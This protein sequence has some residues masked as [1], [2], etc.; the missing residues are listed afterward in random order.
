MSDRVGPDVPAQDDLLPVYA[1]DGAELPPEQNLAEWRQ[2]TALFFDTERLEAF[3]SQRF[4]ASIRSYRMGPLLYGRASSEG[5]RFIRNAEVVARGGD[6]HFL[7]QLYVRGSYRGRTSAGPI[8]VRTG[9]ISVLDLADTF[10]TEAEDFDNLN[11]VVPRPLLASRLPTTSGLHG[12]VLRREHAMTELLG[13][14][15]SALDA[16]APRLT[17]GEADDL[18]DASLSFIAAAL[19]RALYGRTRSGN[20]ELEAALRIRAFVDA[21]LGDPNLDVSA[22][23]AHFGLSRAGLYRLFA[24][25]GRIGEHI[26]NERLRGAFQDLRAAG[27]RNARVGAIGRRWGFATEAG[28]SRAFQARY[29]VTPRAVRSP[30]FVPSPEQQAANAEN[31]LSRWLREGPNGLSSKR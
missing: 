12:L 22:V 21:N 30:D 8:E 3:Q 7:V 29:G 14:H 19:R 31:Q 5:Q 27:G 1:F 25:F 13:Q 24:P 10:E 18:A 2:A 28:F 20:H 26:R 9:D 15:L 4:V 23:A 17:V 11:I 16:L 6:D